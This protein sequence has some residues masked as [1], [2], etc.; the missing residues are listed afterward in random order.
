MFYAWLSF[1]KLEEI[2]QLFIALG[3]APSCISIEN[4]KVFEE[5]VMYLY[6]VKDHMYTESDDSIKRGIV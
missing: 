6:F 2:V 1:L 5:F 3:N 4:I